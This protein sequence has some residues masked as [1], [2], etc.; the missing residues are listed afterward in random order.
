MPLHDDGTIPADAILFRVLAHPGWTTTKGGT[1]RP[2]SIAF[3]EA[4][5]EVSY[6]VDAPGML[7]EL[8]RIFPGSE[9]A[10]VPALVVRAVGFA[11]ERRPDECPE[12]FQC[13]RTCHV[14][15]G[16]PA[17]LT[18]LEFQAKARRIAKNPNV[19]IVAIIHPEPPPT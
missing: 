18:R 3:Y 4:A 16:P 5:G 6:F 9:I 8:S 19:T 12:D 14:V 1:R 17:E 11:I 7:T 13:D 2:S 10:V 15:A